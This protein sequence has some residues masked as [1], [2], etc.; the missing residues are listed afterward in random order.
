M[1]QPAHE[2][3]AQGFH[4]LNKG[5]QHI[6]LYAFTKG[7]AFRNTTGCTLGDFLF[8]IFA[9]IAGWSI[10]NINQIL[11]HDSWRYITCT[12]SHCLI[13]THLFALSF[14]LCDVSLNYLWKFDTAS[15]IY[16]GI[17]SLRCSQFGGN[18]DGI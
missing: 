13:S 15:M 9:A 12:L 8:A 17:E 1:Q 4:K 18:I 3:F 10:F 5:I 6:T 2:L 11:S 14:T 16:I 7:P